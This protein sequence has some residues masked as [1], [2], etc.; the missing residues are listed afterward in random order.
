VSW[1]TD[2]NHGNGSSNNGLPF[3][4]DIPMA[5]PMTIMTMATTSPM[6]LAA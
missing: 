4:L 1:N 6:T 3:S 5:V 2:R